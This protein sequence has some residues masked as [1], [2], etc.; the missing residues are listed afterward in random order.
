MQTTKKTVLKKIWT[1]QEFAWVGDGPMPSEL[2]DSGCGPRDPMDPGEGW[3]FV[4]EYIDAEEV[5]DSW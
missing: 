4:E 5:M 2:T 1:T 3:E